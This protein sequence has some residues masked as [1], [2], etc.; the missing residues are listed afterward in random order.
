M[1]LLLFLSH[2]SRVT[3]PIYAHLR[4]EASG[5]VLAGLAVQ[6]L[7]IFA[8]VTPTA[9][10]AATIVLTSLTVV[11]AGLALAL[12]HEIASYALLTANSITTFAALLPTELASGLIQKEAAIAVQTGSS[13]AESTGGWTAA[14]AP[15][16]EEVC[17]GAPGA[18]VLRHAG[19]AAVGARTTAVP[20]EVV[21]V[22]T[23]LADFPLAAGET[24]RGAALAAAVQQEKGSLTRVAARL[25]TVAA[26]LPAN[27][28]KSA[29]EQGKEHYYFYY[30]RH[31][32]ISPI[33]LLPFIAHLTL[34]RACAWPDSNH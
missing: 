13:V 5:C 28:R 18:V 32:I 4:L 12:L 15:L 27:D 20:I 22:N 3:H 23:R 17:I 1:L 10:G 25:G 11:Q 30:R 2:C 31:I 16:R 14:T 33:S 8:I 9:F 6:T 21:P 26:A 29:N 24:V 7:E 19:K 34:E